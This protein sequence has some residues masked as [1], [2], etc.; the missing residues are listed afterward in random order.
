MAVRNLLHRSK[1]EDFKLWLGK[2]ALPPVGEWE[3]MRWKGPPGKPMCV[4]F[5]QSSPEHLSC[6]D[7]AV[8]DVLRFF[9]YCH[10]VRNESL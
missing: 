8:R 2:R 6:N 1:L 5:E 7:A 3:V 10:E 9:R 4:V